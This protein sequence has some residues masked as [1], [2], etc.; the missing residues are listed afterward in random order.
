MEAM[1][2]LPLST[3]RI[4]CVTCRMVAKTSSSHSRLDRY[5]LRRLQIIY[6]KHKIEWVIVDDGQ[7]ERYEC[8]YGGENYFALRVTVKW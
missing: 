6:P 4:L 5:L 7:E 3:P 1:G 8:R 2:P